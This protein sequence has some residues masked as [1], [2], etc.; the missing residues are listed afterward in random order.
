M[1]SGVGEVE[2][3]EKTKQ[4]R[5]AIILLLSL[6]ILAGAMLWTWRIGMAAN[7]LDHRLE[8]ASEDLMEL[9]QAVQKL[10]AKRA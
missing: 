6:A 2:V 1:L 3:H 10:E 9:R 8:H 7:N 5:Q 4:K